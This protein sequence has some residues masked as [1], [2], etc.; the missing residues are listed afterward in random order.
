MA[1]QIDSGLL[2]STLPMRIRSSSSQLAK[3]GL[4]TSYTPVVILFNAL[5]SS[6]LT[7]EFVITC[8]LNEEGRQ[9]TPS[10]SPVDV[11]SEDSD[12]HMALH[13]SKLRSVLLLFIEGSLC[14]SLPSEGEG[15]QDEGRGGPQECSGCFSRCC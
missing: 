2:T 10:F 1:L 4:P 5:D 8:L 14:F 7:L 13:I 6:K 9:A 12:T 11:K 3:P 15:H